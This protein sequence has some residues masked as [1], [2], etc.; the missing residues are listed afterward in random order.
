MVRWPSHTALRVMSNHHCGRPN[1]ALHVEELGRARALADLMSAQ[2]PV[3]RN[4]SVNPQSWVGIESIIKKESNCCCLYISYC[5]QLMAMWI[6]KGT[7]P[8]FVREVDVNGCFVVKGLKRN[9][10][11]VF[12][13]EIFRMFHV[14]PTEHCE[15]RSLFLSNASNREHKSSH[16]DSTA[17][18]RLI[19]DEED[20]S[21]QP[22][23]TLA[24]CYRMIIAP[25]ADFLDQPELLI[26]PDRALYKVPFAALKDENGKYLAESFRIRIVP[27]L[28]TLKLIQG[29]RFSVPCP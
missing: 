29:M 13:N 10:D 9:V 24:E 15:D 27:S 16:E 5:A 14:L 28:T 22:V 6:L 7:R 17:A 25:V 1:K 12:D 8:I 26:V 11:K 20:E 19:E 4:I 3:K 2:Y 21:Q 18:F 23:P